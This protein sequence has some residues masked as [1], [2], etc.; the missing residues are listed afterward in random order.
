MESFSKATQNKDITRTCWNSTAVKAHLYFW[1][2]SLLWMSQNL[3]LLFFPAHKYVS[4]Q[5]VLPISYFP[6]EILSQS[7]SFL[8]YSAFPLAIQLLKFWKSY[9]LH[10]QPCFLGHVMPSLLLFFL[11]ICIHSLFHLDRLDSALLKIVDSHKYFTF[12]AT[13][14]CPGKTMDVHLWWWQSVTFIT[15]FKKSMMTSF[16]RAGLCIIEEIMQTIA[17][18]GSSNNFGSL[19]I[20]T[21]RNRIRNCSMVNRQID[22]SSHWQICWS[23]VIFFY[24][25]HKPLLVVCMKKKL[26]R[27]KPRWNLIWLLQ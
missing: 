1:K 24:A 3:N 23:K 9:Q 10:N 22:H 27:P 26:E 11:Y 15:V 16:Y 4:S 12:W 2:I 17:L 5:A 20:L 8:W 7:A 14:L 13:L 18:V 6:W 25:R 19:K 21:L